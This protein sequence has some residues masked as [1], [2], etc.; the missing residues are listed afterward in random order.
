MVGRSRLLT[1]P[2]YYRFFSLSMLDIRRERSVTTRL[3]I[4]FVVKKKKKKK[5]LVAIPVAVI[6]TA[7]DYHIRDDNS[8]QS[9]LQRMRSFD[10]LAS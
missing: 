10:E 1:I 4:Y 2:I 9:T 7:I 3:M 5:I 6:N 8:A